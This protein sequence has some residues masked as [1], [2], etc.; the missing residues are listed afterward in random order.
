[1]SGTEGQ[2][3]AFAYHWYWLSFSFKGENQGVCI[4]NAPTLEDAREKAQELKIWPENDHI[5]AYLLN[6]KPD[7]LKPDTLI[8][9]EE[10]M[11]KGYVRVKS[12]ARKK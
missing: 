11:K 5:E 3:Y 9:A 2:K 7:D 4:I 10:L 6:A 1:M 12:K 8:K